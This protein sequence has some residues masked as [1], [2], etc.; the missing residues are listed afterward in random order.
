MTLLI[1]TMLVSIFQIYFAKAFV[2]LA[3]ARQEKGY[4]NHHPRM[5]QSKLT[6][7]GARAYA[8]HLNGFEAFPIFA[9]G[10]LLN[11]VL[12]TDL[13]FVEILAFSFISLRFFYIFFYIADYSYLRSTVWTIAFLCN[14][15]MYL[16]PF[17]Y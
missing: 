10:T 9:I 13:Y 7:W 16:L 14:M 12:K 5:Q 15:G 6:G 4:D 1:I 2:A 3:M 17:L 8:A 11:M